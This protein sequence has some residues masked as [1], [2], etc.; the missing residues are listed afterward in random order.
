[1]RAFFVASL[2][3]FLAVDAL[4][5]TAPSP[6]FEVASIKRSAMTAGSWF[7]FLPGGRL[8]A[9]SWVK[10][11]I[12]IAYG[13]E[14]YQVTGGPGWI[15]SDWYDIEAKAGNAD[16]GKP[17]MTEMLQSLLADRFRLKVRRETRDFPVFDLVVDANSSK[18]KLLKDGEASGCRR[19]NSFACG[20]TNIA[21]LAKAL[22]HFVG[23]PV[24]DKT[25]LNGKFDLLLDFDTSQNQTSPTDSDKP[26]LARALQEQLGLR[27]EPQKASFPVLAIENIQRP[28]EN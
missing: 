2:W 9:T 23:R 18:L 12:Q 21:Q 10:Q 22:E 25:G 6:A 15:V 5:Q 20:Y 7:R 8:S 28:T 14:D 24:L 19:D 4:P 1:M 17:E 26:S 11:M 3:V 16:A 13:V 27:L